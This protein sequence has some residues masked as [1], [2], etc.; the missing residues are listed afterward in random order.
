[1]RVGY[2]YYV[3][4]THGRVSVVGCSHA[5]TKHIHSPLATSSTVASASRCC[6]CG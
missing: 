6:G 4:S 1:M 5:L 2:Y 3:S